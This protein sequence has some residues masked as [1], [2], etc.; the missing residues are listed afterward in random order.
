MDTSVAHSPHEASRPAPFK[1]LSVREHMALAI[2]GQHW[3]YPGARESHIRETLG[4]SA[5]RHAQV[6]N[7]LIDRVEAIEA[8]PTLCARLRRL[9]DVR[10]GVRSTER[11][12][13]R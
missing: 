9:R 2:E 8:Y 7:A 3:K 10:R 5:I 6:V 12:H 11:L 13:A 4:W 1:G